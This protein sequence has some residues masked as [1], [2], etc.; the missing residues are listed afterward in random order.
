M[1]GESV[2]VTSTSTT[3]R[4]KDVSSLLRVADLMAAHTIVDKETG[5]RSLNQDSPLTKDIAEGYIE[6]FRR[7]ANSNIRPEDGLPFS[8][9]DSSAVLSVLEV[10]V[11]PVKE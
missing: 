6:D 11:E 8:R 9:S 4:H 7:A 1:H 3:D 5:Q 10:L 2:L